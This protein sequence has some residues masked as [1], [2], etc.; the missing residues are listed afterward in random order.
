MAAGYEAKARITVDTSQLLRASREAARSIGTLTAATREATAALNSMERSGRTAAQAMRPFASMMQTLAADS[1]QADTANQQLSRGLRENATAFT[2]ASESAQRY[3]QNQTMTAAGARRLARE[4]VD[5]DERLSQVRRAM[6]MGVNSAGEL[7]TAYTTL[8]QELQ[9]LRQ[10]YDSLG[11]GQQQAVRSQM[12]LITAQRDASQAARDADAAVREMNKQRMEQVRIAV[13]AAEQEA[14]AAAAADR[15][16]QKQREL[17]ASAQQAAQGQQ[18]LAQTGGAV[19]AGLD[20]STRA[21]GGLDSSLWAL[22]SSVGE[23]EGMLYGLQSTAIQVTQTMWQ[24]FSTQEMAI[25]QISRVSQA[26]VTE[27]DSIVSQVRQMSREIPIAFD[28]LGRIAMLGSQVGVSNDALAN[29]T[30]TVALFSATSEVTAED[31]ATLLARIMQMADVPEDE[32]MNLGA[33]VA[34][35]GSNSAATDAEIL[36]TI[37]SIATI[38]NQAG[39]SETA[40][41]GLGGAMASLRIR[42]ELARG[43]MQRV[44]N[45][46]EQGARGSG[47]AMESLTEITGM[48][49]DALVKLADEGENTDQFFFSIIAGLSEMHK[50]GT[51]LVPVLREMGIIN[52]RDVDVLA[53]LAANW[54]LVSKSLGDANVAFEEGTYLYNE[55]D[56]IFNT[57]TARVQLLANAWNEFLFN[58]VEGV[59]PFVTKIV[60]ATTEVIRFADSIGAAPVLGFAALLLAGAA[61]LGTLGIAATTVTR[62]ILALRTAQIAVQ[63]SMAATTTATVA[64]TGAVVASATAQRGLASATVATGV[65]MRGLMAASPLA[66]IAGLSAAVLGV[67][68]AFDA[69]SDSTDV[70]RDR[71][72]ESNRA[73]IEAAGGIKALQAAIQE[74]TA[75]WRE[76]QEA[77]NDHINALDANVGAY[78]RAAEELQRYSAFRTISAEEGIQAAKDE[79]EAAEE[80]ETAQRGVAGAL[81]EVGQSSGTATDGITDVGGAASSSETPVG[82]L[83]EANERLRGSMEDSRTAYDEATAA[84]GLL[85]YEWGAAVLN[86]ALLETTSYNSAEALREMKDAGVDM[87]SALALEMSEAGAGA[88]YLND[89]ADELFMTMNPFEKLWSGLAY[90]IN[91][92]SG[93][94]LDFRTQTG[95]VVDDIRDL[96]DAT[97]SISAA[98]ESAVESEEILLQ[99]TFE[100]A[101]GTQVAASEL[102]EMDAA[103]LIM[104]DTI[105]GLNITVDQL[106]EGFASF[107]DPVEAWN[108]A[109]REAQTAADDT[110]LSLLNMEGGFTAYLDKLQ[111]ASEAQMNWAQNLLQLTADGVPAEVVAGLTEM[112]VEGAEIVQGLVDASDEEVQRFVMLWEQGGGAVLDNF[113]IVFSEFMVQAAQAGDQGGI[114]F[115]NNLLE[116]VG[117]GEISMGEAVDRMTEYAETEFDNADPT[118]EFYGDATQALEEMNDL[119]EEIR[120]AIETANDESVVEPSWSSG[121]FWSGIS[122]WWSSVKEWWR[123]NV[124]GNLRVSPQV[125]G[126]Y[127]GSGSYGP[128]PRKDGGWVAGPGG[129][130]QDKIPALLS[131]REFVVNARSAREFGP[132]LEWIN[133]QNG[134]GGAQIL[135]PN[136]VPDDIFRIPRRP[137]SAMRDSA[138][139]G[140][141][142]SL[143]SVRRPDV[144][145]WKIQINNQY[146]Q[147][148]PTSVTVNRALAYAAALDGV[149]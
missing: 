38:G 133:R 11:T 105:S 75:A 28:E 15:A 62:G 121:G 53:R 101:D 33:A 9:R 74:D 34:Y 104:E 1:R 122:G 35:L 60:E 115:A 141:R 3:Q 29:F 129:T 19:A 42:P 91:K 12:N 49:Q 112:G 65:A 95:T 149:D 13:R 27:L 44:F 85:S 45:Q 103:A 18:R 119:L 21:V 147:A 25:A 97:E 6:D 36:N 110:S 10:T 68:A 82:S 54:D 46:L 57:L 100:L 16:A 135:T 96:A 80:L 93:G 148:E 14:K 64:N 59:A 24:N 76:A 124:S 70:A 92:L 39:L 116:Q 20:Q 83:F 2:T 37:E 31:T 138:P 125:T 17:A 52:T 145:G 102:A 48:S 51:N 117:T 106:R 139:A 84:L 66:W 140:V 22:R 4:I 41:I 94:F 67:R 113:S 90:W 73:H 130:R 26:T 120:D 126:D 23:I 55:S 131:D 71:L 87:G 98:A 111:E 99:T 81:A 146:P 56:R 50:E 72:I 69:F 143:S 40:I 5:T 63:R 30:E 118:L 61:A 8:R 123:N 86:S 107:I 136:F 142:R 7:D 89:R 128:L 134:S 108:E 47:A 114:D 58:A 43:A 32:V 132:L 88:E 79:K 127:S 77:A 144:S 137:L 109:T 78:S